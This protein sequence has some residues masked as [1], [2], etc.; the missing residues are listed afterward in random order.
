MDHFAEKICIF[1]KNVVS[2]QREKMLHHEK[3]NYYYCNF[4]IHSDEL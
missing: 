1:A 3:H 4:I 2:L